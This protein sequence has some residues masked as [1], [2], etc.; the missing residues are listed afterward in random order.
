ML[1]MNVAQ[2]QHALQQAGIAPEAYWI[3]EYRDDYTC[4]MQAEDGMWETFSGERGEKSDLRRWDN[5]GDACVFFI[6]MLWVYIAR[7]LRSRAR[8]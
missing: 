8:Q 5:E 7:E 3:G 2:L 1:T 4:I 6:G